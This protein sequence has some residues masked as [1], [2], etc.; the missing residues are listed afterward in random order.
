MEEEI[1]K[2]INNNIDSRKGHDAYDVRFID[3]K[4][5]MKDFKT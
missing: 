4:D 2:Y 1:E 5:E 3:L